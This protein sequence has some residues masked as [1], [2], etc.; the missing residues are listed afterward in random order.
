MATRY[1]HTFTWDAPAAAVHAMVTDP[2][3]QEQRAQAGSPIRAESSVSTG[4]G[5]TTISV[6]RLMAID[7]PGFIKNFVGDSIGI[8]ETQTWTS[9]A[10]ASLLVEI[11]KQPGDVRGTIRLTE[12]GAATVVTVEAQIA[13][14]VPLIGGKVEGYVAGIVDR[15]L[16]K[17]EELG[18]AWLAGGGG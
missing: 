9:P 4:P 15:L 13:V 16:D 7:P 11:L 3:Y 12:S 5:G 2:V 8:Q 1:Q 17:D 18:K 6:F 14:K 10:E